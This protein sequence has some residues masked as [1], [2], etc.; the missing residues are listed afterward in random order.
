VFLTGA[1]GFVGGAVL[2]ELLARGHHVSVLV[3]SGQ[4]DVADPKLTVIKGDLFDAHAL[5]TALTGCTAAIH[6]VGI[7]ME[8]PSAGVTF[9]RVHVDGTKNVVDRAASAGVK[10][11]VHMSAMGVREGAVSRYQTT[12]WQ[13]EQ[14]VRGS[15]LDWTILRPSMIHGPRGEF[16]R[17]AAAWARKQK[18]PW[19]F[20]PYFGAGVLGLGRKRKVQPVHVD[21]VARA[22]ADCLDKPHTVGRTYDLGGPEAITWP[23]MHHRFAEA[24]AG[25]RRLVM[26]IPAWY[27]NLVATITPP[28]LIPFNKAQVQMALDDNAAPLDPFVTDFGWAPRAF[29]PASY[30]NAV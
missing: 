25:Q 10:R 3:R 6:L 23:Q 13:A 2:A 7:I 14:Y 20:M 16:T 26:P 29:D 4:L 9:E 5:D 27:G 11:Y 19:L 17:M 15:T 12:K 8:K 28:S 1:S 18:A 21:D 24:F 30:A 22:F